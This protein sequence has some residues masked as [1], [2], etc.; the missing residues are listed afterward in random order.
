MLVYSVEMNLILFPSWKSLSVAE[1]KDFLTLLN[2]GYHWKT[3]NWME[4][5]SQQALALNVLLNVVSFNL[6]RFLLEWKAKAMSFSHFFSL[7][8]TVF[9]HQFKTSFS[10]KAIPGY[11][12]SAMYI[13]RLK[14]KK[15]KDFRWFYVHITVLL[16]MTSSYSKKPSNYG[17]FSFLLFSSCHL[18]EYWM[19]DWKLIWEA[20]M[21]HLIFSHLFVTVFS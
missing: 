12:H 20:V 9:C 7:K 10:F 13:E 6:P 8:M 1:A 17:Q 4:Q 15:K 2:Q 11:E 18:A 19:S 5:V 21:F 3:P 14:K 16:A